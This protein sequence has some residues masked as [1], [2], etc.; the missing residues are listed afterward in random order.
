MRFFLFFSL[1]SIESNVVV[2]SWVRF[3]QIE[4]RCA[5]N[6]IECHYMQS[7]IKHLVEL[8]A[9]VY[10]LMSSIGSCFEIGQT[11]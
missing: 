11:M 8:W 9:K 7:N 10:G 6:Q 3:S 5:F 1:H 2:F 4:H